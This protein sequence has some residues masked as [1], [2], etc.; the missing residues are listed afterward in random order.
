[1]THKHTVPQS[2]FDSPEA[3]FIAK[4]ATKQA[5]DELDRM[6][7]NDLDV[8]NPNHPINS[9]IFCYDAREF[10]AKQYRS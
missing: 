6:N 10:L 4:I 2:V 7:H 5:T 8:G 9:G 1:M 3:R